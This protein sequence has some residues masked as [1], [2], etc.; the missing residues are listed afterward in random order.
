MHGITFRNEC[1]GEGVGWQGILNCKSSFCPLWCPSPQSLVLLC[2][3]APFASGK[4]SSL[5]G[6]LSS[7]IG[8]IPWCWALLQEGLFVMVATGQWLRIYASN[9]TPCGEG[10]CTE[11]EGSRSWEAGCGLTFLLI[12]PFM[13]FLWLGGSLSCGS[14]GRCGSQILAGT[15]RIKPWKRVVCFLGP[16]RVRA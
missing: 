9:I 16:L 14:W 11:A 13:W 5:L 3:S 7:S 2:S 6:I 1:W 8:S 10:L 4:K 15:L 12:Q